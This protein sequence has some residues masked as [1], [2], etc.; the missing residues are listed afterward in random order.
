MKIY[1]KDLNPDVWTKKEM[2]EIKRLVNKEGKTY[3]EA[4]EIVTKNEF[5]A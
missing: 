5:D 4:F 3:E 1:L 2:L